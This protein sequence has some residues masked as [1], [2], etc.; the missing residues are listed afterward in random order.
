M[1]LALQATAL[2]ALLCTP[3]MLVCRPAAKDPVLYSSVAECESASEALQKQAS[4]DEQEILSRCVNAD[5]SYLEEE[6]DWAVTAVNKLVANVEHLPRAD[7]VQE[8]TSRTAALNQTLQVHD[9]SIGRADPQDH[10]VDDM[11]VG[12]IRTGI[13]LGVIRVQDSGNATRNSN[14]GDDQVTTITVSSHSTNG[15]SVREYNV[16]VE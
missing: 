11:T 14:H 4:K 6:T 9:L 2:V 5:A 8:K 10:Q 12:T 15:I 7:L 13:A 1:P 16:L 3:D